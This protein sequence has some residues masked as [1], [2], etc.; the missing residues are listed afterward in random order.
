[1]S[2]DALVEEERT[3]TLGSPIRQLATWCIVRSRHLLG[4]VLGS[5]LAGTLY[6]LHEGENGT[7]Y[8]QNRHSAYDQQLHQQTKPT[9]RT[10]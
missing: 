7:D 6:E 5:R 3:K 10:L 1:M 9:S 4:L 8:T 2:V